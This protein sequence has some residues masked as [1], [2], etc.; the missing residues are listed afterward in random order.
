[1]IRPGMAEELQTI[2]G[3]G[4]TAGFAPDSKGK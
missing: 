3:E 1:M 4:A 2:Q